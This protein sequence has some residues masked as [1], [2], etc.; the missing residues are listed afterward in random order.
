MFLILFSTFSLLIICPA[1]SFGW[2]DGWNYYGSGRDHPYSAYIDRANYV[3]YADYAAFRL[4]YVNEPP[5]AVSPMPP[6]PAA[7]PGEFTVNIPNK[8]GGYTA[9]VIKR[10]G[11]GFTGPQG[12]YYPDFPKVFQLEIMYGK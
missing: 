1:V 3:G 6:V 5:P 10:T 9:V 12:E 8:H 4:D 11:N 2:D 7:L